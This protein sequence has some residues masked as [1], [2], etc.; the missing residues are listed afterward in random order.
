MSRS[1]GPITMW[2]GKL[3]V[4]RCPASLGFCFSCHSRV[5][6]IETSPSTSDQQISNLAI[7]IYTIQWNTPLARLHLHSGSDFANYSTPSFTQWYVTLQL[8]LVFSRENLTIKPVDWCNQLSKNKFR[9]AA[10][11]QQQNVSVK[12]LL[13]IL[14]IFCKNIGIVSPILS[15]VLILISTITCAIIFPSIVNK[16]AGRQVINHSCQTPLGK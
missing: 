9:N 13:I 8:E 11:L 15:A 5:P 14:L 2:H 6:T 16:T 10:R 4:I 3:R 1:S 12:V 7:R